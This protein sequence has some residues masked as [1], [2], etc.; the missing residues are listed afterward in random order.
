MACRVISFFFLLMSLQSFNDEGEG[1][2]TEDSDLDFLSIAI[3]QNQAMA[4]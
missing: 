2:K 4:M 3:A 1:G